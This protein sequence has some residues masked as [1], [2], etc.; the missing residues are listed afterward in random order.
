[1]PRLP[2][3]PLP[4][5][6]SGAIATAR[7]AA[8]SAADGATA[9]LVGLLGAVPDER[10]DQLMRTPAR[11]VVVETIFVLMPLYLNRTRARGLNLAVRWQIT[12]PGDPDDVDVFDL[13]IAERRC[14]TL[15]GGGGPAPLVTVRVE[16]VELLR[17][18]I[19]RVSP[20]QA[21]FDR[22][23]SLSGDIMQA[24]RLTSLFRIPDAA[25]RPRANGRPQAND[26]PP[27]NG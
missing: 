20:M 16:S 24:A 25:G 9:R 3:V 14:R 13:V 11:R 18:A 2:P 8:D 22:R 6:L 10:L 23:L 7:R 1:M 26:K 12:A 27:S 19:G 21:Y 17:L 15:R 4:L 5:Q